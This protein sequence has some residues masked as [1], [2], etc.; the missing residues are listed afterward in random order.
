MSLVSKDA[1]KAESTLSRMLQ[2][3]CRT[4]KGGVHV[5]HPT[6]SAACGLSG[7]VFPPLDPRLVS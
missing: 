5:G 6:V 4:V 3:R 2:P 7:E 1:C